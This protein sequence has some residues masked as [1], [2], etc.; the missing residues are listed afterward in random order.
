MFIRAGAL[1]ASV[2]LMQAFWKTLKPEDVRLQVSRRCVR[3]LNPEARGPR[4]K[5]YACVARCTHDVE[6]V[7]V[8]SD[9]ASAASLPTPAEPTADPVG[10]KDAD[11][12]APKAKK[13]RASH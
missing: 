6:S 8:E 9:K 12:A 4:V 5:A 11:A 1:G 10:K 13:P 3:A 7:I 2:T